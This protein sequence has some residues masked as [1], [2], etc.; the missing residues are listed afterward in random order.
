LAC[1]HHSVACFA[2]IR[3]ERSV[4]HRNTVVVTSHD[5][6]RICSCP[7][8]D[9]VRVR[10]VSD[11]IAHAKDLIVSVTRMIEDG[12]QRLAVSVDVAEDQIGQSLTGEFRCSCYRIRQVAR[13]PVDLPIIAPLGWYLLTI[14]YVGRGV[15]FP[16]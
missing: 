8:D 14:S 12:L 7:I 11:E 4:I 13:I 6:C 3:F 16:G 10:T 5:G 2:A 1:P 15:A 9:E